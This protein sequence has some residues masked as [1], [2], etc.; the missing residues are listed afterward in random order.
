[1]P[2][3]YSSALYAGVLSLALSAGW[4]AP[5]WAVYKCESAGQ[6]SYSDTACANGKTLAMQDD[7]DNQGIKPRPSARDK[8]TA[9]QLQRQQRERAKADKQQAKAQAKAERE[10][11]RA[12]LLQEKKQRKCVQLAQRKKWAEDEL[13]SANMKNQEK[14]RRKSQRASDQYLAECPA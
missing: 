11:A 5:A 10:E 4:S 12:K 2:Y 1:M 3:P 14:A 8:A 13:R 7:Q 6:V 9:Q